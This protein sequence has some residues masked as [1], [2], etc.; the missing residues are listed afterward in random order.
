M[1]EHLTGP[2]MFI[3]FYA[4]IFYGILGLALY[5]HNQSLSIRNIQI[6]KFSDVF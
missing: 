5:C 6:P 1:K 3:D 2:G 4:N